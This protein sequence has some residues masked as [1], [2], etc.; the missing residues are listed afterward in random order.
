MKLFTTALDWIEKVFFGVAALMITVMVGAVL[1]QVFLRYVL[2]SPTSWSEE[3]ATLAFVWCVMLVIPLGIR[4]QEHISME[5]LVNRFAGAKWT[6]AQILLN[7]VVGATLVAI[8]IASFGLLHSGAR[9]VL[10]GITMAAGADVALLVMY[11]AIP[12]GCLVSGLYALER[13]AQLARGEI[14]KNSAE[15]TSTPEEGLI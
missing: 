8:G 11:L 3:V 10:P 12:V 9:Q 7:A 1:L 14:T 4:H 5:F 2:N 13:I 6:W 15:F